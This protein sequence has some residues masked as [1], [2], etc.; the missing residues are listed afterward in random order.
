MDTHSQAMEMRKDGEASTSREA[1]R[2]VMREQ[3]IP[4]SQQP[5]SQSKSESGREYT[6][7]VPKSGGG[8]ETKVVQQQT[9]DR[10]HE[11]QPHWEV[12]KPKTDPRAGEV[13]TDS[14]GRAKLRNDK[15]KVEYREDPK[16][17]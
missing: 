5:S 4:T 6:Y 1:R 7:E 15:S 16:E 17:R 10:G 11:S 14:Y 12:G 8:T 13:R 9:M 2:E 3:G